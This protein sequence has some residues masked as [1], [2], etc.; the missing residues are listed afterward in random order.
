MQQQDGA[1]AGG[2][3][4][5]VLLVELSVVLVANG[6]EPSMI[7]PDF[8][9]HNGIVDRDL[10]TTGQP[11]STPVFSQATF[12]GGVTVTA[13][14]NRFVFVQQ[15]EPLHEDACSV[16]EIARRFL[17]KVSH[18]QYN[19]TGINAKAVR[20]ADGE[21]VDGVANAL[22]DGGRWMAFNDV[23]PVVGLKAVYNYDDRKITLNIDAAKRKNNDGSESNGLLFQVNVH[24]DVTEAGPQERIERIRSILSGWRDDVSDFELLVEKV[25]SRKSES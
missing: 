21:S 23:F 6:M 10:P 5:D 14:P 8:L 18:L 3:Q 19:A 20:S 15:A 12:E 22:V 11:I 17:N 13:E 9:R 4:P 25:D 24:R 7:N 1:A 16:P 2:H